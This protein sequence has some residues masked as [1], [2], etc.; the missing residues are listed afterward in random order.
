MSFP[1]CPVRT[2]YCGRPFTA[3]MDHG[4]RQKFCSPACANR[5][6]PK[7]L[8]R[9]WARE[10]GIANGRAVEGRVIQRFIHLPADEAIVAAYRLGRRTAGHHG[11]RRTA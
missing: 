7:E 3:R 4:V 2:C 6:R 11:Q 5:S 10:G 9:Q 1:R 8:V